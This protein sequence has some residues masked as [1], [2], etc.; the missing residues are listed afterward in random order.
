MITTSRNRSYNNISFYVKGVLLLSLVLLLWQMRSTLGGLLW[1]ASTPI[2]Y[3]RNTIGRA[4][5]HVNAQFTSVAELES[6]NHRLV[7]E[8]ASAT[9]LLN[10]RNALLYENKELK[11]RLGRSDHASTT[12][13]A[14]VARPP[15]VPYDIFIVDVGS[16]DAVAVG[17]IVSVSGTQVVGRVS[18]VFTDQS[19]IRL[20]SSAG[21]KHEA[22]VRIQENI[23][24]PITLRGE[25]GGSFSSEVPLGSGV[26]V[27]S[28]IFMPSI[29]GE[30]I[31]EVSSVSTKQGQPSE[32]LYGHFDRT[33]MSVPFVEI[34]H[35][36]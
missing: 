36:L 22:L 13:A 5:L 20:Y 34:W 4:A 31:V 32:K 35:R 18:E 14:V 3:V 21:D 16:R 12:L 10:D 26:K 9:L 17:D 19:R 27:G 6:E 2:F 33:V 29:F 8:L 28:Q 24:L 1:H 25:G 15:S 11:H 7:S 30:F 23:F